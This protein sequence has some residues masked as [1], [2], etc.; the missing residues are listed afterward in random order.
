VASFIAFYINGTISKMAVGKENIGYLSA[1][2]A[3]TAA[4][5]SMPLSWL[6]LYTGK[7]A[8]M[9]SGALAYIAICFSVYDLST[10]TLQGTHWR[11]VFIYL[12][13]GLGRA[14][15]EVRPL[16]N[17]WRRVESRLSLPARSL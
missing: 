4:I 16:S 9:V 1:I 10:E 15:F 2:T 6:A 5:I 14:I 3:G 17:R 7:C 12:L 13:A 8:L 11:V